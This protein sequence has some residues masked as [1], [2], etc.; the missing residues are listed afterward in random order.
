MQWVDGGR[1]VQ[2]VALCGGAG[3]NLTT[4]AVQVGADAFVTGEV[5]HHQL[6]EAQTAGLTLVAAG[7]YCTERVVL[8]PLRQRL[9]EAFPAVEFMCAETV[10]DPA[11]T[12]A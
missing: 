6:L 10:S 4:Q 2:S 8:E 7:H 1:P 9:A 3:G 5:R 11:H 12:I